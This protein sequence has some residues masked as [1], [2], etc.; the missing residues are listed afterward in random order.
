MTLVRDSFARADGSLG[1]NWVNKWSGNSEGAVGLGDMAII[2]QGYGPTNNHSAERLMMWNGGQTFGNDQYSLAVV[3]TIAPNIATLSITAVANAGVNL[4]TYTYTVTQGSV[5]AVIAGGGLFAQVSGMANAGNNITVKPQII[6]AYGAGTFTVSSTTGV[7]ESGSSGIGNCPSDS[8]SGVAVRASNRTCY[9][10]I[11]G[12]NTFNA[13]GSYTRE[14]WSLINGVGSAI[15]GTGINNTP[16]LI[17]D[18]VCMVAVG[19][20]IKVLELSAGVCTTQGPTTDANIVSGTP[21]VYDW[22]FGGPQEY[23]WGA[24]GNSGVV[25]SDPPGNAGTT[26]N[27]WQAGDFSLVGSL[28]LGVDNFTRANESPLNPA[29]WTVPSGT[30]TGNLQVVSNLCVCGASVVS[31]NVEIFTGGGA[32]ASADQYAQITV[33]NVGSAM[34]VVVRASTS[35]VTFYYFQWNNAGVFNLFKV[36]AGTVTGLTSQGGIAF[37]VAGDT[38]GLMAL[39]PLLVCL[40]NG[41]V[42]MSWLDTSIAAANQGAGLWIQGGPGSVSAF[43][44]GTIPITPNVAGGGGDLGPGYDLKFGF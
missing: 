37:P 33:Q 43:S 25:G 8:T 12:P 32:P 30:G 7:A 3:K 6:T 5:A 1:P 15:D 28:P 20:Q 29:N 42:I 40:H 18:I 4:W 34:G 39:G 38:M 22:C 17:G 21:G 36:V 44:G 23:N 27:N 9:Y 26:W 14:M 41:V 10:Q 2:S 19:T 31:F 16:N 11:Q 24:W 13:L 35:S